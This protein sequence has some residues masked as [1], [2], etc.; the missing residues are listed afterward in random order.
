MF[1]TTAYSARARIRWVGAVDTYVEITCCA[2]CRSTGIAA[3]TASSGTWVRATG[4]GERPPGISSLAAIGSCSCRAA[5]R[6][7][8]MLTSRGGFGMWRVQNVRVPSC[9]AEGPPMHVLKHVDSRQ[10]TCPTTSLLEIERAPPSYDTFSSCLVG[11]SLLPPSMY[12]SPSPILVS[13]PALPI[14]L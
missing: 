2:G 11:Y 6:Q 10:A 3:T 4:M 12:S 1:S 14:T 9:S 5:A 7:V 13:Y 8:I